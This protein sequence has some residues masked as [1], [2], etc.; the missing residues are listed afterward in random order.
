MDVKDAGF[1]LRV[2]EPGLLPAFRPYLTDQAAQD[3]S[4]GRADV[5]TLGAVTAERRTCAAA[6]GRMDG[7][8]LTVTSLYVDP[9]VRRRGI[10]SALLA[11][12][13]ERAAPRRAEVSWALPQSEFDAFRAF[14]AAAGFRTAPQAGGGLYRAE[15]ASLR[16]GPTLRR[17]ISPAFRPDGNVVPLA[18]LTGAERA[19][20]L[21]DPAI[22]S[23]LGL[24]R[25]E[26]LYS[27]EV[28]FAYRYGGRVAAY[29][30]C[31]FTGRRDGSIL[32]AV[33][34]PGAHPAAILQLAAAA[35]RAGLDHFGGD[36]AFWADTV[37][38]ES[39]D[40]LL[41]LTRG[42]CQLWLEGSARWEAD[43]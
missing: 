20:L 5:L 21:A 2:V 28:S 24:A 40:L 37:N 13:L 22:D 39:A 32:A 14:L 33:S 27:P 4:L 30:A 38:R 34:R 25:L 31:A 10:G 1:S 16:L 8:A 43:N 3:G 29:L 42:Q 41:A 23:R 36:F 26:G 19:E 9:A 17:A 18:A 12:L 6:A 11:A 7:A 15:A 35:L